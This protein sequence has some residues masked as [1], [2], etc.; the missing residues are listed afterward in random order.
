M[1]L[2][3][4]IWRLGRHVWLGGWC[5]VGA[6]QARIR[7][8]REYQGKDQPADPVLQRI[9]KAERRDD[10]QYPDQIRIHI[11][12]LDR[13]ALLGG[14]AASRLTRSAAVDRRPA[15]RLG[16]AAQGLARTLVG[17]ALSLV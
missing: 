4:P 1:A 3:R 11:A 13:R 5:V 7:R 12:A 8:M 15:S 6:V 17:R 9:G 2:R 14:L 16:G 10:R